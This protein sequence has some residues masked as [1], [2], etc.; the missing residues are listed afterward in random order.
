MG[1]T[2]LSRNPGGIYY[3]WV[4]AV[5][6][7]VVAFA[8]GPGQSF[9]FA[10]FLDP[11]IEETGFSRSAISTLYAAGTGVSAVMVSLVSRVAD[12]RGPRM[13]LVLVAAALGIVCFVMASAH[14]MIVFV[15]AFAAL[16]AL[17]QGMLP[18]NG[19]LLVAQWFVRYRARAISMMSLG[20]ACS[21]AVLPPISRILIDN[22]G[23]REAYAF[24]G[25]MVWVLIIPGSLFLVRNRPED[26]GL[27][28]DGAD[29]PSTGVGETVGMTPAR[30][31]EGCSRLGVS[32]HS[33]SAPPR[34]HSWSQRSCSTR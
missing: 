10:V 16:R 23:W 34:P 13:V 21:I 5:F 22:L 28:P 2:L 11:M 4:I 27:F 25:L 17:G 6:A 7:A 33:P 19:T 12:R 14:S 30:T 32:G 1:L 29:S 24:L 15:M 26:V 8:S 20:F 9:V 31:G 18:V 3:G